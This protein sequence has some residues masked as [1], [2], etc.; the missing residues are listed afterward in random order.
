MTALV[1]APCGVALAVLVYVL[2][3]DIADWVRYRPRKED[4][5]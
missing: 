2:A 3:H 4:I 5:E 1:L